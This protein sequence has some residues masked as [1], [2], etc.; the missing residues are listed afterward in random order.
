MINGNTY[1]AVGFCGDSKGEE[2]IYP[3]VGGVSSS[4]AFQAV[5]WRCVVVHFASS[6]RNNPNANHI[7]FT[8]LKHIP[9]IGKFKTEKFLSDL[10][11]KV[12]SLP[13]TYQPPLG[14]FDSWRST[15]Y[16][17]DMLKYLSNICQ[18][19]DSCVIL[20]SDCIWIDSVEEIVFSIKQHGF[21]TYE[22]DYRTANPTATDIISGLAKSEV[23]KIYEE[24]EQRKLDEVPKH[25]GAEIIAGSGHSMKKVSTE[26]D[27]IWEISLKRATSGQPKFNT[28][29]YML[30]Y[31]YKKIGYVPGTANS[32]IKRIWTERA[33]YNNASNE[34]FKLRIWHIPAEK[35]H[36]IKRLFMQALNPRSSFWHLPLG[37]PFAQYVGS[38][39][40]IPE[41]S[42]MKITLDSLNGGIARIQR[43]FS[44]T[45]MKTKLY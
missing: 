28:E 34:D 3:Q 43:K 20:D 27:S 25:F 19:D 33:A 10:K 24:L 26:I 17:F 45:R 31:V 13:F 1:I 4:T 32:Y 16:K 22:I 36:G 8:N 15:F 38:Y 21:L 29:E 41:A 14:Y 35:V 6:V 12:V 40:G 23:Q 11:V 37:K 5:Y 39:L 44:N 9:D 2:S 42:Y 30:S 7:L 18:P